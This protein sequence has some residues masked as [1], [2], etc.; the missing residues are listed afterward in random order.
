MKNP[1]RFVIANKKNRPALI[2]VAA[3]LFTIPGEGS[4]S[5]DLPPMPALILTIKLHQARFVIGD[6]IPI[7]VT[8]ENS[9]KSPV[10]V[11]DPAVGSEFQFIVTSRKDPRTEYYFSWKR[12]IIERYPLETPAP[13]HDFPGLQLAPGARQV[14]HEDLAQFIVNPLPPGEYT[15]VV[16]Y[17]GTRSNDESITIVQSAAKK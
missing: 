6:S 14:Y 11:P 1:Q 17:N 2:F 9:G 16:E 5:P 13:R 12:A 3:L 15:L 4:M 10:E 7:E 8:L